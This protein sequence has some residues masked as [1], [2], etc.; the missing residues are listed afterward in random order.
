MVENRR[1]RFTRPDVLAARRTSYDPFGSTLPVNFPP[2]DSLSTSSTTS[3]ASSESRFKWQAPPTQPKNSI[4]S[5]TTM[6]LLKLR[7][8]LNFRRKKNKNAIQ[9]NISEIKILEGD[10]FISMA[11]VEG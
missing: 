2:P 8:E 9:S 4:W 1:R 5:V 7:D 3:T 10:R 6:V 11:L